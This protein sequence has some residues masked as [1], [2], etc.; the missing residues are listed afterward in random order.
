MIKS[1]MVYPKDRDEAVGL[2]T[3]QVLTIDDEI[4]GYLTTGDAA[5]VI[6][7]ALS[8]WM[9]IGKILE[10]LQL[11]WPKWHGETGTGGRS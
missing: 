6:Y 9:Q 7:L 2:K 8:V 3:C 11:G 4:V 5:R 10:A 1:F